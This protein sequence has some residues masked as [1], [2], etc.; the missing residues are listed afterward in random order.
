MILIHATFADGTVMLFLP[1]E[2]VWTC[3]WISDN[4]EYFDGDQHDFAKH[5]IKPGVHVV[6]RDGYGLKAGETLEKIVR[7]I[8]VPDQLPLGVQT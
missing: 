8:D 2:K 4:G 5:L 7:V 1:Y 3:K 6:A